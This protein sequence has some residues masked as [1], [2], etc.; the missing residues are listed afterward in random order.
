M[1]N[2]IIGVIPVKF[3]I[4]HSW[5]KKS[6][7][8]MNI[9]D[10]YD[11]IVDNSNYRTYYLIK[12]QMLIPNFYDFFVQLHR[13]IGNEE[14]LNKARKFNQKYADLVQ[15][16]DLKSFLTYFIEDT[17]Y[18]PIYIQIK[19]G[20]ITSEID[21]QSLLIVYRGSYNVL[22]E[23]NSSLMHFERLIQNTLSNPLAS[24]IKM[25]LIT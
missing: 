13:A 18:D 9:N 19:G 8:S 3:R 12:P 11:E 14:V 22:M 25:G 15:A 17:Y 6:W 1:S 4:L 5:S 7:L 16:K 23:E 24:I 2:G 10:F 20:F 21:A